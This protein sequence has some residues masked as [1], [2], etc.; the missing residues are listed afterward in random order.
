[1]ILKKIIFLLVVVALFA[2][3]EIDNYDKPNGTIYGKLMDIITNE[4]LQSEQPNGFSIRLFEKGNEKNL[5]IV[6]QG[7]ADGTF[8]NAMI[9]QN[10]YKVFPSEGAF[11]PPDTAIVQVG[12]RT[13]SNFDVMPFLAVTNVT[14]SA[15]AGTV[16]ANYKIVRN[17]VGDKIVER[18]TLVSNIPTVNNIVYIGSVNNSHTGIKDDVNLVPPQFTDVVSGL[19]SGQ[20][21]Y[22]RVAVR[23]NNALKRWNYSKVFT[24]I[25]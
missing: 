21:Y 15:S 10:E 1:M 2:S 23:T 12:S 19:K 25:P 4:P 14:V 5:P 22:V 6:F 17:K 11:F 20:T 9:F 16:T 13:E 3:C 18:K 8:E 7:K 24:V